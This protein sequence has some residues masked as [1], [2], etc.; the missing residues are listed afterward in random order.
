M[1]WLAAGHYKTWAC[2]PAPHA[3]VYPSNHGD[4]LACNNS[5]LHT[6]PAGIG[7]YPLDAASVKE[8]YAFDDVTRVGYSVS[9]KITDDLGDGWYWF[10]V[11]D[12][13]IT[14]GMAT[15]PTTA[16]TA[17]HQCA[18]RDFTYAIAP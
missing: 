10:E 1:P 7:N 16:C 3:E 11:K 5:I 6:A 8:L 14:D 13:K 18:P 2:E 9:R 17:C 4:N 12:G 15:E